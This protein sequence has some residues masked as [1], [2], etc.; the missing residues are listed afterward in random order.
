MLAPA[1]WNEPK[2]GLLA[3]A[4][5]PL[6]A[7]YGAATARRMARPGVRLP[8][9]VVCIGNFTAGGAGKTPVAAEVARLLQ[10]SGERVFIL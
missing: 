7:I 2:R 3:Q 6:A 4:L 1:F 9:P 5:R 10:A 8:V